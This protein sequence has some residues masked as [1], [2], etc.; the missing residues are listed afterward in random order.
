M[1]GKERILNQHRYHD[2]N[3]AFDELLDIANESQ[4][5][6]VNGC[7]KK[8]EDNGKEISTENINRCLQKSSIDVLNFW[9]DHYA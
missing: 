2:T 3:E 1:D 9:M 6:M 5:F 4:S 7:I 8:L